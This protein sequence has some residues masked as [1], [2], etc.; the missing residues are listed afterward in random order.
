MS[1]IR[2]L[3]GCLAAMTVALGAFLWPHSA[4]AGS[5]R[6]AVQ[7]LTAA[8]HD[9][10]TT[11][12]PAQGYDPFSW[13]GEHEIF[14]TL[15]GYANASGVAGTKLA[16]DLA[17][18]LPEV[19]H[20][21]RWYTFQLRHNVRFSPP[22]NRVVTS[23]DVQFSIER[24]LA[25]S[26]AGPMYQSPFWSPLSGTT[27]FWNG[28]AA[29]ISGIHV[30]GRFGIQ[31]RLS[32]PDLAFENVLAL[33]FAAAVPHETVTRYGK[34]FSDHVVG[35]GP[36]MLQS[37]AHGRQM[38]LIANPNYFRPG[39]PHIPRVVIQFGVDEH[40]Q[41][42]RAEKGQLDLPGNLVTST[43]YLALRTSSHAGQLTPTKDIGV[44][45]VAMNTKLAPFKGN[46]TL[47]RAF[48]D[49]IDKQ[50]ILRLIN[51]RGFVVNGILPAT[52]PGA[53]P[54][55]TYYKYDP[56]LAAKELKQAGYKPGRLKL[57]MLFI[58]SPDTDKVADAIQAD[59]SRIGVSIT[60]KPVSANTAYNLVYTPGKSVLTLF[61]WGQDYP[62]PSD[63]VDPILTC[64]ASSNAAFYCNPKVD[65]LANQ[66]RGDTNTAHRYA[67]YR[68]IEKLVMAD[69]PWVPL[70]CDIFYD[71]HG[72]RVKN[73]FVHPVWPFLYDQYRLS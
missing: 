15:L 41:I 45:Y 3:G 35:T 5:P 28:K 44:W 46:V 8:F 1:M 36:Y 24:A 70:Y 25:K 23:A 4:S 52:M 26:T 19:S 69:A 55:F 12:D 34:T 50:H 13:T 39:I 63:F 32:S 16:P 11:L 49:A 67:T 59:L 21:G 2:V 56:A 68:Q 14:D 22:V 29:H 17:A 65:Q 20:G 9:D 38:V 47:R 54:N 64:A 51:Q 58:E 31:F 71:F 6:V 48:N 73:F 57:T 42:L 61:H 62:D 53:N 37:W 43:D 27:P 10:F 40:L 66:A 72:T 33:P 18:A 30:L 60:L 7:T